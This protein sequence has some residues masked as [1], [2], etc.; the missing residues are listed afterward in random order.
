MP[1]YSLA[2]FVAF[3]L[4]LGG[5]LFFHKRKNT[6]VGLG[7]AAA[8]VIFLIRHN[9]RAEVREQ[10][11]ALLALLLAFLTVLGVLWAQR[12]SLQRHRP[13][14]YLRLMV[15]QAVLVLVTLARIIQ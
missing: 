8:T 15:A 2:A 10:V 1:P 5:L 13:H 4:M 9:E 12:R 11:I 3:Y 14:A 7:F 6:V